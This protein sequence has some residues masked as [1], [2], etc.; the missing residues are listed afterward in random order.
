[1]EILESF[2]EA[3]TGCGATEWLPDARVFHP[4]DWDAF[5]KKYDP[6]KR[7][8]DNGAR[9]YAKNRARVL[10]KNR[11]WQ[12]ANPG[13]CLANRRR[14]RE[15]NAPKERARASAWAKANRAKINAYRRQRR[16]SAVSSRTSAKAA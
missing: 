1:M 8:A 9:W 5:R 11:A 10:A 3:A 12:K 2:A 4:V 16:L 15:R 14:W 13:R 6:R 7:Q